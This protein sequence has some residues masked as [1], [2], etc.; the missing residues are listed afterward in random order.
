MIYLVEIYKIYLF[1]N[2]DSSTEII[3]GLLMKHNMIPGLMNISKI[4]SLHY[5]QGSLSYYKPEIE[6]SVRHKWR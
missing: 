5:R 4:I 1:V 6:S 3:S 2:V